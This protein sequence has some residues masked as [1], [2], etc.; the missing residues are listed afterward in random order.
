[1]T[2]IRLSLLSFL[3][4]Q[5]V[6]LQ[7]TRWS[8]FKYY[9]GFF[10]NLSYICWTIG[11]KIPPAYGNEDVRSLWLHIEVSGS[12][13]KFLVAMCSSYISPGIWQSTNQVHPHICARILGN[14]PEHI[15][16]C[17]LL[18]LSC[19]QS[20]LMGQTFGAHDKRPQPCKNISSFCFHMLNIQDNRGQKRCQPCKLT[21]RD[22][23][24]LLTRFYHNC[25]IELHLCFLKEN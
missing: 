4:C 25:C 17:G 10:C 19:A 2:C 14:C 3:L 1:M 24:F 15:L 9:F 13:L 18:D 5:L 11:T 6:L 12:I 23:W 22:W 7:P 20:I 21:K 16:N 8:P